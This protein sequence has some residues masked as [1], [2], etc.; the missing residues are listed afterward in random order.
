MFHVEHFALRTD[1]PRGNTFPIPSPDRVAPSGCSRQLLPADFLQHTAP[2]ERF[3]RDDECLFHRKLAEACGVGDAVGVDQPRRHGRKF[4][5]RH[6]FRFGFAQTA[7]V[8]S[9]ILAAEK[10]LKYPRSRTNGLQT[11]LPDVSSWPS[12]E[13]EFPENLWENVAP[14][15]MGS[16]KRRR[17]ALVQFCLGS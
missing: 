7:V 10:L 2:D 13:G 9:L 11:Q 6:L 12:R 15:K 4:E 3:H 8:I 14:H 16:R 1:V 17:H 5:L